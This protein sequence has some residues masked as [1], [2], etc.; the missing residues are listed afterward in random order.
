MKIAVEITI[1]GFMFAD[2]VEYP[3]TP[4]TQAEVV[5][6]MMG[7][8]DFKWAKYETAPKADRMIYDLQ[9]GPVN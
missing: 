8:T 1:F 4:Q 2:V 9:E 3:G 6:W 5:Q 7:Q